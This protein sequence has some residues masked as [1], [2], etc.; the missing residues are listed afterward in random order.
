MTQR[1]SATAPSSAD[2]VEAPSLKPEMIEKMA[3]V[4]SQL[5]ETFGTLV[6]AVMALPRYRHLSL[7]DLQPV[8]LDPMIRDRLAI[9]QPRATDA[10][11]ADLAGFAI[12]A[13]VSEAVD[14]KIREQ[15]KAGVWPV[16]LAPEDWTSGEINWLL[17]VIA[18]DRKVAGLVLANF[19]QVVKGGELRLHPLVTKMVEPEVLEKLG[20]R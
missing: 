2:P 17:D 20:A 14:A 4:R 12:W 1:D 18:P 15:I 16:R 13:S 10:G 11:L 3:A 8:L 5:R 9:A 7:A 6:M 19:R